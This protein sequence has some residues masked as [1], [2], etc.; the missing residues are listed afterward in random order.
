MAV[1]YEKAIKSKKKDRGKLQ[2]SSFSDVRE[3]NTKSTLFDKKNY[4]KL[5]GLLLMFGGV[6]FIYKRFVKR[7]AGLALQTV[8]HGT[9]IAD[10]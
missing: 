10:I 6:Y 3:N 5:G 4:I 8:D 2:K 9:E 1:T 7:K